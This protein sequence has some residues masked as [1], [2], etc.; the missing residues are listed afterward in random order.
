[1]TKQQAARPTMRK[2]RPMEPAIMPPMPPPV[3]EERPPRVS[4]PKWRSRSTMLPRMPRAPAIMS[5]MAGMPTCSAALAG[6]GAGASSSFTGML[7]QKG[8]GI[9][10][11]NAGAGGFLVE[12]AHD[13]EQQGEGVLVLADGLALLEAF[14]RLVGV[15]DAADADGDAG[16]AAE[17]RPHEARYERVEPLPLLAVDEDVAGAQHEPGKDQRQDGIRVGLGDGAIAHVGSLGAGGLAGGLAGIGEVAELG[18]IRGDG[19]RSRRGGAH[20]G[21]GR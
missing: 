11:S 3:K 12:L 13:L 20:G 7:R 18:R 14:G 2:K 10:E 15:D 1:M 4:A 5:P 16:H 21:L 19:N 9:R 8:G 6:G 17:Q